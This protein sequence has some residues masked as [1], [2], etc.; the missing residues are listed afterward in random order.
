MRVVANTVA[1]APAAALIAAWPSDDVPPRISTRS[2][3]RSA[4]LPCSALHAVAYTSGIAASSGHGS[5]VSTGTT[6]LAGT[7]T[8]SA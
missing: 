1:P 4:G 3:P 2:P 6:L 7:V 8:S 5:P